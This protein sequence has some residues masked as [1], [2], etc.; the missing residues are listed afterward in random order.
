M[1]PPVQVNKTPQQLA[2]EQEHTELANLI[3]DYRK[4]GLPAIAKYE[5]RKKRSRE[6][7]REK[8][9]S[10]ARTSRQEAMELSTVI[11]ATAEVVDK[12][13]EQTLQRQVSPGAITIPACLANV[14]RDLT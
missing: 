13:R 10:D 6:D 1:I 9:R 5:K 4:G 8:G 7:D 11:Q 14:V 2:V 12:R 3:S